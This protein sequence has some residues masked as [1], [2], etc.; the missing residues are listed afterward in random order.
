MANEYADRA[1]TLRQG[2]E[3]MRLRRKD[4]K[5]VARMKRGHQTPELERAYGVSH[6]ESLP[7]Q[8]LEAFSV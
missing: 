3:V 5:F 4:D 8:N 6:R 2:G 1:T 7:D